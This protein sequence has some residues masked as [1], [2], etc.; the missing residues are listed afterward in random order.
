MISND[1]SRAS[2]SH[3]MKKLPAE[4]PIYKYMGI[5]S[6]L[7]FFMNRSLV[8]QKIRSWPDYLE[9]KLFEFFKKNGLI[10]TESSPDDY[11]GSCWTLQDD[12]QRLF[13]S[14]EGFQTSCEEMRE[15]G[16][17]AMWEAYC[18]DGGLRV[19]TT[20]GKVLDVLG[21][22]QMWHGSIHYEPSSL[23]IARKPEPIEEALFYKRTCFRHEG[24]YR[25]IVKLAKPLGILS[26][27]IN[28]MR[29]FV[30]EILVSPAR[31]E[32]SWRARAIY[33]LVANSYMSC[34]R[35][36]INS[37]DGKQYCRISEGV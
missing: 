17:A 13:S 30:D 25:F 5:D 29:S 33:R 37:K 1:L 7:H 4:T 3:T 11:F 10:Q 24:E 26:L 21:P 18:K 20:I 14:E 27:P 28:N 36:E 35:D 2:K 9:G 8:L 15:L 32:D 12:D 22:H 31:K 19:K 34:T 23:P 16:S 6:F